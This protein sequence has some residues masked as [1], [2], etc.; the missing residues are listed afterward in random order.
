MAALTAKYRDFRFIIPFVV[1]FGLYISPVG[2][3]SSV[4]PDRWRLLYA[5]NPIVGVI[6]GFRWCLLRGFED[7]QWP[8]LLVSTSAAALLLISGISYFRKVERTLA[9][10]I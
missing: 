4:V 10:I 9:D 3:K 1:Q 7:L 5:I 2:F 6:D 8:V